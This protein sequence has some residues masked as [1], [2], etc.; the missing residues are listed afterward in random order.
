MSGHNRLS[1]EG[2]SPIRIESP[3]IHE[4]LV[5]AFLGAYG[6]LQTHYW[7]R[8][9]VACLG[10]DECPPAYHRSRL[11][12]K[13]Y[14]PVQ[15]FVKSSGLW[16][17]AALE[18]TEGAEHLLRGRDLVGEVWMFSR[19]GNKKNG[20][21]TGVF[22][23]RMP[24]LQLQPTFDLLTVLR[25]FYRAPRLELDAANTLVP[26]LYATPAA[27]YV[28]E[29]VAAVIP[30]PVDDAAALEEKKKLQ[31]HLREEMKKNGF[32]GRKK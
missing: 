29:C 25:R 14:A 15:V 6:G 20:A 1:V 28:P 8:Q 31:E 24:V 30:A 12:W 7:Q 19:V 11:I 4:T 23:E 27:G 21:V 13:G 22:C 9:T 3:R 5:V 32:A 26:R 16:M 10:D 2:P 17:L 18:I